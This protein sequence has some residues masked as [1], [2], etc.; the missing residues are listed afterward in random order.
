MGD[1]TMKKIFLKAKPI[2]ETL[3]ENGFEAYFVGGAVRDY[4]LQH[5]IHD[6][7]I[8]TSATPEKVQSLFANVVPVG[9]EH[10]TVIVVYEGESY[11]VT[12]FRRESEYRDFRRPSEVTFISSL[13][14]DLKRRDFTMNAIAMTIRFELI[15]PFNG[16]QDIRNELIR[17]VGS[18]YE[19]F[20]EDPLRILRAVRFVS[21]LNFSIE[22]TT[23]RAIDNMKAHLQHLSIERIADEFEK[24]MVGKSSS[25][26]L[27]LV[28]ELSIYSFLPRLEG[29]TTELKTVAALSIENFKKNIECW[30]CLL[31]FIDEEPKQFLKTWKRSR[32]LIQQVEVIV[33]A[34]K[35]ARYQDFSNPYFLYKLGEELSLS[36][37]TVYSV[38]HQQSVKK[39]IQAVKNIYDQL[40]IKER[41]ELAINGN[42]L[43]EITDQK[44]G[45]WLKEVLNQIEKSVIE[46][47]LRNDKKELREWVKRWHNQ[48]E[49][50]F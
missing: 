50:N 44:Q 12:T 8:A 7:D 19:R 43:M 15:D 46:G 4:L 3:T 10:G 5:P 37:V 18:P 49:K 26:A 31:Y 45:P 33:N 39:N 16:Q 35:Q 36:Y 20:Q 6:V 34:L 32:Q 29:Y 22:K 47:K 41:K 21:Q 11:E 48:S 30:A 24:M 9:I 42:D 13:Y 28:A 1:M 2:I 14:E 23:L 38:I 27:K 40:P 17:T 25:K